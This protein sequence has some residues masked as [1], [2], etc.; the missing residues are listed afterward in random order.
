MDRELVRRFLQRMGQDTTTNVGTMLANLFLLTPQG[1]PANGAVLLFSRTPQRFWPQALVQCARFDGLTSV[2]FL[3]EET[4]EGDILS[5]L[6]G[7]IKFVT[8]NT[9]KALRITGR[10]EHE[11]IP[12]YPAEAVRE[13]ILNAICHRNYAD[14]S[15]T[16][17]RIYDDRLEVWN[18]GALPPGMMLDELYHEHP[19]RPR[20]PRLAQALHRAHLIEHW[21]TGT[22]R[23][24]QAC[25]ESGLPRPEF[26]TDQG[27]FKVRFPSMVEIAKPVTV[28]HVLTERQQQTIAYIREHGA[29]TRNEYEQ[30]FMVKRSQ[31]NRDL[32]ELTEKGI[33]VMEQKGAHSRYLL[34]ESR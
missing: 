13:A 8:R 27:M 25:E 10:P 31:A 29:I 16:Q 34:S 28:T 7:A 23:I 30:L 32:S 33:L 11:V 1:D 20:N 2:K 14:A 12:E 4:F 9:R 24:V 5:Q 21:G 22:V 26:I 18:P 15:A 6:D 19:S 3:D 17:I